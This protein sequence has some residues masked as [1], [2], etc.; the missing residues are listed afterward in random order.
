MENGKVAEDVSV[1]DSRISVKSSC[2]ALLSE[3]HPASAST[4]DRLQGDMTGEGMDVMC[5]LPA[6]VHMSDESEF[7]EDKVKMNGLNEDD[8]AIPTQSES[9]THE[10]GYENGDV[11]KVT[12]KADNADTY[13]LEYEPGSDGFNP[14]ECIEV[15]R[16]FHEEEVRE[17]ADYKEVRTHDV[18][19]IVMEEVSCRESS[20]MATEDE[21][22]ALLNAAFED[23]GEM[24][25]GREISVEELTRVETVRTE[26][27]GDGETVMTTS[28][29]EEHKTEATVEN[30]LQD[31]SDSE[32]KSKDEQTTDSS[33]QVAAQEAPASTEHAAG[34]NAEPTVAE[35]ISEKS[36]ENKDEGQKSKGFIDRIKAKTRSLSRDRKSSKDAPKEDVADGQEQKEN[37]KE[38]NKKG[39]KWSLFSKK[40]TKKE[41]EGAS[42]EESSGDDHVEKN[43]GEKTESG[44]EELPSD[45]LKESADNDKCQETKDK[46]EEKVEEKSGNKKF[47]LNIFGKHF[48]TKQSYNVTEE[49]AVILESMEKS[50]ASK[51]SLFGLKT[52]DSESKAAD[53]KVEG[54]DAEPSK[55]N[56]AE[57]PSEVE[58]QKTKEHKWFQFGKKAD[59]ETGEKDEKDHKWH[60]FGKK[61]RKEVVPTELAQEIETKEITNESE[62]NGDVDPAVQLDKDDEATEEELPLVCKVEGDASKPLD[63]EDKSGNME[64]SGKE[65]KVTVTSEMSLT[66]NVGDGIS[67]TTKDSDGL[68]IENSQ[69]SLT[70]NA[71]LQSAEPIEEIAKVEHVDSLESSPDARE[72]SEDNHQRH[73]ESLTQ[74]KSNSNE[75]EVAATEKIVVNETTAELSDKLQCELKHESEEIQPKFDSEDKDIANTQSNVQGSENPVVVESN[76]DVENTEEVTNERKDIVS[77]EKVTAGEIYSHED[78][79]KVSKKFHFG[80]K[81]GAHKKDQKQDSNADGEKYTKSWSPFG[82]KTTTKKSTVDTAAGDK[83]ECLKVEAGQPEVS[84]AC[85]SE[86]K[87][88]ESTE[89]QPSNIVDQP[90]EHAKAEVV[91]TEEKEGTKK[92]RG[93]HHFFS[94]TKKTKTYDVQAHETALVEKNSPELTAPGAEAEENVNSSEAVD[95]KEGKDKVDEKP[96]RAVQKGFSFGLRFGKNKK[97]G[98]TE[99]KPEVPNEEHPTD[100]EAKPP[101]S[102]EDTKV[103]SDDE[104]ETSL[105]IENDAEIKLP[106]ASAEP[107][108]SDSLLSAPD[109]VDSKEISGLSL[110]DA[111]T[112]DVQLSFADIDQSDEFNQSK[113]AAVSSAIP[114]MSPSEEE[115]MEIS[116]ENPLPESSPDFCENQVLPS[117]EGAVNTDV[118]TEVKIEEASV[119]VDKEESA[120]NEE[121]QQKLEPAQIK[122][123]KHQK[124]FSFGKLK[125]GKK[126]DKSKHPEQ[127]EEITSDANNKESSTDKNEND[128][129]KEAEADNVK[130]E[131]KAEGQQEDAKENI[132]SETIVT[133]STVTAVNGDKACTAEDESKH[134]SGHKWHLFGKKTDKKHDDVEA[135]KI[136]T[137]VTPTTVEIIDVNGSDV[138][139]APNDDKQPVINDN[140]TKQ[141]IPGKKS[142]YNIGKGLFSKIFTQKN[143]QNESKLINGEK[144]NNSKVEDSIEEAV[145]SYAIHDGGQIVVETRYETKS[146]LNGNHTDSHKKSDEFEELVTKTMSVLEG[147]AFPPD[148]KSKSEH[149]VVVAI[150]FGTT[151]S[152]YAFSFTRDPDSIHMMRKWEGGDPGVINQKTP[153]TI[154]LNPD[155]EF[156]SFGFT[157]RDFYHDL[158]AVEASRWMYFEKFKMA[159]HGSTGE[160]NEDTTIL[161]S[162]G[163]S[164][165]AMML[166]TYA[167]RFFKDHALKELAS[168]SSTPIVNDDIRWVITVP[169]IWKAS[170]KQFMRRAACLAGI[171]DPENSE[172]L[173][174]ALE[175][176]AASI[177]IRRLRRSQLVPDKPTPRPLSPSKTEHAE[178]SL[179]S[180]DYVADEIKPGTRY[181]VVDCGGGT[182]DITVHEMESETGHLKELYKATGGP[183]GSMEV[184]REFERLMSDIFGSEFIESFKLKRPA[185]WIDLM[186]A[187]ESRKRAATPFRN[188]ASNI[189][190]PFSFIDY[191]K[192]IFGTQVEAAIK[193]FSNKDIRW[194]MQ[195]MLRLMPEAMLSLFQ[196]TI[197]NIKNAIEHVLNNPSIGGIE[198]LFLVGGFAE[199]PIIQSALKKEFS[200]KVKI[201]IPQDVSLTILK[202]AVCFGLDPTVITVRKSRHTY[203]V[204]VVNKFDPALHPVDKRMEK[205]GTEWCTDIFEPFVL[206]DQTVALGDSVVRRYTP[207]NKNQTSSIIHIYSSEASSV[208]FVTD[209]GVRRCGTLR[210]DLSNVADGDDR[211]GG[212]KR[213]EIQVRMTFGG[214]EISTSALDVAA[215]LCVRANIDF[216]N[217]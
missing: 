70:A 84:T 156:H 179:I 117:T 15:E 98:V 162:N 170:A 5:A 119:E 59:K 75:E 195:G 194:S 63:A 166:F 52:K 68:P 69:W 73:E 112:S 130:S 62:K 81:L 207:A 47:K 44:Q 206:A 55:E 31:L 186:I 153:T 184:D 183:Y 14:T 193:R 72:I 143:K 125:F 188:N 180:L 19:E 65:D 154:L 201:V 158:D 4:G 11:T 175:P 64:V 105:P 121:V 148:F 176:E 85:P 36:N 94:F 10:N 58:V 205:D 120:S 169:A 28:L 123:T 79:K 42:S 2:Q 87:D 32:S 163:L 187:F 204:G 107:V 13:V 113:T 24:I 80:L 192:K 7:S 215:G 203:G 137:D 178:E 38:K 83:E 60:P 1:E 216:L 126:H 18:K 101:V 20:R 97:S 108:F 12:D 76:S 53:D 191:H 133:E 111:S 46:I 212:Q 8:E 128:E 57:I 25:I 147:T 74:E 23:S 48:D 93:I 41:G 202:G 71:S 49:S 95:S 37:S 61:A 150:D 174:I 160:L 139:T 167:L 26:V 209:P 90:E 33:H 200:Q 142:S 56:D 115:A 43:V 16:T 9:V 172:S 40:S 109:V 190:L 102:G 181:M 197:D 165:S 213:R 124:K 198:Y 27:N 131:E 106:E 96:E 144:E 39:K 100:G 140:E 136:T 210:L 132:E 110:E 173:L 141:K 92:H 116:A 29:N 103:V 77:E 99:T 171:S 91:Q 86:T 50:K 182:V 135:K 155:G 118:S 211:T 152:G 17:S 30:N 149:F 157:A 104:H 164:F 34:N 127:G 159:L 177:Y 189:S 21:L 22:R 208:Q 138:I 51:K 196:P 78:D 122:E 67:D 185:G 54:A 151:F 66:M 6:T 82:K 217:K 89:S 129:K 214:T 134:H 114:V 146:K 45:D 145:V 168:Q 161:A 199:S 35:E 88:I 3:E